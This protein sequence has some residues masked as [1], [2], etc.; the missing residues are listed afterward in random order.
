MPR[1]QRSAILEKAASLMAADQEEFAVL[2]V[3]EAGKTFTQARKEVTRCINN[4][5]AFC[6][7]SQAQCRRG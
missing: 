5:Q 4:A 2:I 1:H 6:R 3:R 7:R